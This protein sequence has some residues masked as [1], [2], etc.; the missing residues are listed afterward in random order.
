MEG[1]SKFNM[2]IN[3]KHRRFPASG[4]PQQGNKFPVLEGV[5]H[6]INDD[7]NPENDTKIYAVIIPVN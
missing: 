4:R 3:P 6:V 2:C 7:I 1:I 5:V